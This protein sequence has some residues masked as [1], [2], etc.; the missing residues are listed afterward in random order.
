MNSPFLKKALP[1]ILA[2]VV[3]LVVAI[4][5][6]KPALEGLILNQQDTLQ[7]KG[8]PQQSL[9]YK[10]KYGR[11]PLWT[12]SLFGGMPAYTIAMENRTK[13]SLG[14]LQYAVTWG[15]PAPIS[16]FF[17]ACLCFYILTQVLRI[18]PWLGILASLAY[19]YSTY[20]P[21]IVVVGHVT[22]MQA[23]GYAPGVI[24]GILL[25][26][27]RKWLLG[28]ALL[29]SFFM[30]QV[31]TQHLQVVYYTLISAGFLTLFYLIDSWKKKELKP[32]LI[33]IAIAAGAAMLGYGCFTISL[34]PMQE[35]T[36]E[37]M[38]G[39]RTEL[40]DS[41][42]TEKYIGKNGGLSKEYAFGW[43]YGIAETFTLVVPDAQGGGSD[44]KRITGN[45]KFADKLTE[46]GVPEDNALQMANGY[47]Y[48]GAQS[49]TAGPV[50]LGAVCCMLFILGLVFVK[51][52]PKWWL[53]S[54]A[55]T[56]IVLSWGKNFPSINYFLFD[57]LPMYNKFRAPTIAMIMPQFAIPLLGALGLDT[58]LKSQESKD[59][60]WKKFKNAMIITAGLLVVTAG[61]YFTASYKAEKDTMV[62]QNFVHMLSRGQQS[63]N[64]QMQQQVN[65]LAGT[66]MKNLREDRQSLFG[67]DLFRS[68]IL[69]ALAT[70]LIWLYLKG[71]YT[72]KM[73]LLAGMLVLSS[74]DLLAIGRRYLSYDNFLEPAE[75]D[76]Q[77]TATPA[78]QRINADP[79]KN[80]RVYDATAS[81]PFSDSHASYFH[82]SIGGYSPAKL[83][84]YM[85]IIE[86]QL[87]KGNM[88]VF[89]MLNTKYF[90]QPNPSNGQPQASI[91]PGAFGPCWLVKSIHYVK[92][93]NEEMKALDSIN[94]R[95]T[96]VMQQQYQPKVKF[97]PVED[98]TAKIHLIEN[99]NDKITYK[100]SSKTNQFAVFSEIYYDKGWN[101]YIDGNKA[102][103]FRVDYVLRGMSVPAGDHSIEWR[104]EPRSYELGDKISFWCSV[105]GSLLLIIAGFVE[106]RKWSHKS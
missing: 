30:F 81:D 19:A 58:L 63:A 7:V 36:A 44:S 38:R 24:A 71:K 49:S 98:S 106:W 32:L 86:H 68:F 73:I 40:K 21:I 83:G 4:V 104:F 9:E 12:E 85:D 45:S 96:V 64:P 94:L 97:A 88:Q 10:Q 34:L 61:F 74:F 99:L 56:G 28:A 59:V 8:T 76:A 27:Q 75:F 91:N 77:I 51:G 66:L 90:I 43:S 42:N 14:Y 62:Q 1:H 26:Y 57:H 95:D 23:I 29:T 41:S 47:A 89:N 65:E 70:A 25:I 102:D 2:T 50:Y 22:K 15:L 82:N 5:Y 87:S 101:A 46:I 93:G 13:F 67:S 72:E 37:T 20:D 16:Y 60:I 84:L 6:C 33:G 53:V 31:G 100:F 80:F 52:W 69:I 3:F 105:L 92:D 79:D 39:G 48:W 78:D 35:Y 17:A 55:V 11:F 103:Y 54:V 18:N